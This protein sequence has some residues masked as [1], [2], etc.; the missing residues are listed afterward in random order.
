MANKRQNLTEAEQS[1]KALW[2]ELNK[3]KPDLHRIVMHGIDPNNDR[4]RSDQK[5]CASITN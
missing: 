2:A 5:F 3:V 4:D 1:I